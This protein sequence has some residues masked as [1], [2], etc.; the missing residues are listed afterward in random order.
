[1]TPD[2]FATCNTPAVQAL[3]KTGTGP[4]RFYAWGK[5]PQGVVLPYAVWQLVGGLPENYLGDRPD[6]DGSTV[7]VDVYAAGTLAGADQARAVAAALRAEIEK[8]AYITF[9]RGEGLDP[10]TK[11]HT[12]GFDSD[13]FTPR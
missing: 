4:L 3:L 2:I 13:W 5:A 12:Y 11:S 9:I 7:Q 8:V 1:M 6:M 10:D